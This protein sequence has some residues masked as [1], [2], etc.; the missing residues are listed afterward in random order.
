MM[1]HRF[2]MT[3]AACFAVL[4][5]TAGSVLAAEEPQN[6]LFINIDDMRDVA[7]YDPSVK[8]PNLDRLSKM[9]M[10]FKR[11]Y[12]QATF[13]NPSRTSFLTGLRPEQTGVLDNRT[14]FRDHLP[15]VVTL[16]Q[17]FRR[18]GYHAYRLG[19]IYHGAESMDDPV[20]WDRAEYPKI[21]PTGLEGERWY[22]PNREPKW[23][24]SLA[25]EGDEEDQ[26]DGRI[27]SRAVEFLR[28]EHD[29]P[30]FL[31]VGFHKP[32]DPFIA[33]KQYFDLY[34]KNEL[35][36][37]TTPDDASPTPR[38][39]IGGSWKAAFDRFSD[40]DRRSF[41]QAYY[42]AT[43]FMDAQ[44]GR[45][46]D[47]LEEEGLVDRTIIVALSD[48]GYHLGERDWWN[49]STLY[50]YSARAPLWIYAPGMKGAGTPCTR[51]VEFI[52]IYPTLVDLAGLEAPDHL[53]GTSRAA[54]LDQPAHNGSSAAYTTLRRGKRLIRSVRTD[55]W[56]YSELL[57]GTRE[58]FDH[59]NDPG[60][61]HNLVGRPEHEE[62]ARRLHQWLHE[63]Q[64]D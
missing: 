23:C 10:R 50:E 18:N 6:V 58:L 57:D 25:A 63:K 28:A 35:K 29:R 59:E 26:P 40:D 13:C 34:P 9:G 1:I 60:E 37:H 33:P 43:T 54:F 51:P 31:A 45:V 17:L 20:S 4:L 36:L 30:F 5:T 11:A 39:H 24:W 32:H 41:L 46:L 8:T 64:E 62:T 3:A 44:L 61:W 12:V 22:P 47:A 42:A 16:P 7:L 19:K 15:E 14:H 55:R 21:T 53:A 48:H 52:D 38:G 49:K 27:A 56:R 2:R